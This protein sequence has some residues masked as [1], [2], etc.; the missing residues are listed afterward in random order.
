VIQLARVAAKEGAPR[1]RVNA[2]APGGVET[3]IWSSQSFF[4]DLVAKAGSKEAAYQEL[5]GPGTPLGRFARRKNR[6]A[7]RLPALGRSRVHDRRLPGQRRRL[8]ALRLT[9]HS[10]ICGRETI[11]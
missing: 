1:I 10:P 9:R 11:W 4:A 5:A 3:P 7:D 6:G 2:I 8:L